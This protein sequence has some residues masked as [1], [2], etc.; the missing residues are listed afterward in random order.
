MEIGMGNRITIK[1]NHKSLA[2][3]FV[4]IGRCL[5]EEIHVAI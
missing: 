4:D 2:P 5:S 1:G 3:V